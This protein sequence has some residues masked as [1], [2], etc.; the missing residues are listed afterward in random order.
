MPGMPPE[1]LLDVAREIAEAA[2]HRGMVGGQAIDMELTGKGG[3]VSEADVEGI[4]LRKT[5]ALIRAAG[6]QPE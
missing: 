2:G 4:H 3:S 1:K 5:G 6:I